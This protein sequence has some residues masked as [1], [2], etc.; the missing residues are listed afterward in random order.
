MPT[1]AASKSSHFELQAESREK[2]TERQ[3]DRQTDRQTETERDR[4]RQRELKVR[5]VL[6]SQR[7]TE[8]F[9]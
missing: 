9:L 6:D 5:Q 7:V 4:E 2:K 3:T 1:G 8:F